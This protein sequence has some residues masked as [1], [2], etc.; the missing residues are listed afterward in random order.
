MTI[1][2]NSSWKTTAVAAAI[3]LALGSA[4]VAQSDVDPTP[5]T[6]PQTQAQQ[7]PPAQRQATPLPPSR[8]S[9][10]TVE[11]GTRGELDDL[12]HEH[13]EL[14]AFASALKVAGLENSLTNGKEYTVFAPTN[15]ALEEKPGKDID[16]LLEPENRDELISFVRAHIVADVIDLQS[17]RDVAEA[18]TIDGE[19]ID[20]ARDDGVIKIDDA[21]VVN[22]NGIAMGN[23]K[24]YAIDDVL[25]RSGKPIDDE[26]VFNRNSSALA[27]GRTPGIAGDGAR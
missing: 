7:S 15:E 9:E 27:P 19:T 20:I 24:F 3:G 2:H 1:R 6:F 16:T 23:L 13:A 14:S 5:N 4:A 17:P 22:A 26:Q 12:A 11:R 8:Q 25:A 10:Q 18:T 21:K